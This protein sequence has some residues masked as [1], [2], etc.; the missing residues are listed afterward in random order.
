MIYALFALG[1]LRSVPNYVVN[2]D[3]QLEVYYNVNLSQDFLTNGGE[4]SLDFVNGNSNILKFG[5][6][7]YSLEFSPSQTEVYWYTKIEMDNE[8][9]SYKETYIDNFSNVS[10]LNINPTWY[11]PFELINDYVGKTL[12]LSFKVYSDAAFDT[13]SKSANTSFASEYLYNTDTYET[14]YQAGLASGKADTQNKINQAYEEGKAVGIS[15]GIAKDNDLLDIVVAIPDRFIST[16]KSIFDFEILGVNVA[17][18]IISIISLGVV[19]FII[20]KVV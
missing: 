9:I 4:F 11:L 16:F 1:A 8:V 5:K 13:F 10:W 12:K 2:N 3:S 6:G 7:K 14:A 18:L 19:I 15:E 20:K 17:G